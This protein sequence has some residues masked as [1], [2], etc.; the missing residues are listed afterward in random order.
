MD[1]EG[2]F[3]DEVRNSLTGVLGDIIAVSKDRY[4]ATKMSNTERDSSII[5]LDR[6]LNITGKALPIYNKG[7]L[8]TKG[9]IAM[10]P[11][12]LYN[13]TPMFKPIGG[14]TYYTLDGVPYL[15]VELGR[16][17][18][19]EDEATVVGVDES[20]YLIQGLDREHLRR[21]VSR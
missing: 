7:Q 4:A 11:V 9:I 19:P 15:H 16:Y 3:I 20:N 1:S 12:L 21:L 18:Q 5:Y 10:E 13:S 8:S 2:R 17:A 6:D 14:F